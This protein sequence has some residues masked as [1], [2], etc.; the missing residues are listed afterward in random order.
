MMGE[1]KDREEQK[2]EFG[3]Q[4]TGQELE[5][6]NNEK[7][8]LFRK[9]Q[10]GEFKQHLTQQPYIS[11]IKALFMP[12]YA[13][14]D[15]VE[16][17]GKISEKLRK[18]K[19]AEIVREWRR[20]YPP[21]EKLFSDAEELIKEIEAS[22]LTEP[23]GKEYV[24]KEIKRLKE[25][26]AEHKKAIQALL[27]LVQKAAEEA[28]R[29][30]IEEGR[31]LERKDAKKK[32]K[33][34][35]EKK[36]YRAG[37]HITDQLLDGPQTDKG[38]TLDLFDQFKPATRGKITEA[39]EIVYQNMDGRTEFSQGEQK[40]IL[41][42]QEILHKKSN[43]APG[44]GEMDYY[45]GNGETLPA[46]AEG[47]KGK[48]IPALNM[49]IYEITQIFKNSEKPNSKDRQ[50]VAEILARLQRDD[51]KV[52]MRY[53]R[54]FPRTRKVKGKM[55]ELEVEQTIEEYASLINVSAL[56]EK[57]RKE[58]GEVLSHKSDISVR[59][60]PL[61]IDQIKTKWVEKPTIATLEE[62]NAKA[63]G[64]KAP[65]N[66]SKLL[67][68]LMEELSRAKS[69]TLER[70]V[71]QIGEEKLFNRIA[72]QYMPPNEKRLPLIRKQLAEAIDVLKE[73]EL[74]LQYEMRPG[75]TAEIIHH[76]KLK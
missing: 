45:T 12:D 13:I 41:A 57:E 49:S 51:K 53:K 26:R 5:Q 55:T 61:F 64:S 40:M 65:G 6:I 1:N 20:D 74:I 76:F 18:N 73:A 25:Q 47:Y 50:E 4:N 16:E 56:D 33:A 44:A 66:F 48:P 9:E 23:G 28:E 15:P 35:T 17:I 19:G 67:L 30:G 22:K 37:G 68:N 70:G 52:L 71:Y 31:K 24:E 43:T 62:A 72:P 63:T 21:D 29:K 38:S 27:E 36:T 34:K 3:V 46:N 8:V 75:I 59:L 10:V 14:P 54:F 58:S 42:F 32:A 60:H 69:N 2:L 11:Q 39:H 7:G